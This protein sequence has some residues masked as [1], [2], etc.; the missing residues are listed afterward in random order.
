MSAERS[1]PSL[2][3]MLK[4]V[5]A[6]HG[7]YYLF[8]HFWIQA[9]GASEISVRLPSA[10]A[11]GV[12]V[13]G[14]FVLGRML[15]GRNVGIAAAV[16][17][18]VLPRTS[19]L[20]ADA[21]SYAMSTAAAVWVTVLFIVLLRDRSTSR[22]THRFAWLAYAVSLAVGVYLFLYL[23]LLLL[24]HGAYLFTSRRYARRRRPWA[25][26]AGLA[27]VLSLPILGLGYAE[28]G[29]IAFLAHRGYTTARS[30]LVTQWFG[31]PFLA[32]I[33]WA[34]VTIAF[35][36][37]AVIWRRTREVSPLV[38]L[39]GLW[40]VLPTLALLVLNA[41]TP[42]Y[43]LRYLSFC[44]PGVALAIAAGIRML[45]SKAAR[46]AI[47]VVLVAC[48]IPTD[49]AQ[50]GPFAKDGGSDLAQAAAYV[51]KVASPGDGIIFDRTTANRQRPRLAEHLYPSDFTG[52]QDVALKTS[53]L[54][55]SK[56]W[57]TTYPTSD[58]TS[59][60]ATIDRV[61]VVEVTGSPDDLQGTDIHTLE[62]DGY[63]LTSSH[64]VH[65]TII[66]SLVRPDFVAGNDAQQIQLSSLGG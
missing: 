45:R 51:G 33:A 8:L 60:L 16:V 49:V 22:A 55:R 9:F 10:I 30:V 38:R 54:D 42:A 34:I 39:G 65:R 19:Y 56:L 44:I 12:M 37:A 2:F 35:V 41:A 62:G 24:V 61:W 46:I 1:L 40:L 58:I 57:D 28:R 21:R 48:A 29:Q 3:A 53:Y 11:V 25:K 63:L 32:I 47:M 13:A 52:L 36:G 15:A 26:A 4:N 17:S 20:G 14:T 23:G 5:D 66:Y 6:V 18:A 43:N 31:K 7:V 64:L 50:R 27:V 59:R